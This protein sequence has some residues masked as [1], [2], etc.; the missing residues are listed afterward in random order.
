MGHPLQIIF[1]SLCLYIEMMERG[2][3]EFPFFGGSG[4]N[5]Y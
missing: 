3:P 2:L 5:E 4:V 1:F